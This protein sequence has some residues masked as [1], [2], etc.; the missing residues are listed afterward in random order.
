MRGTFD[1]RADAAYIYLVDEIAPGESTRQVPLEGEGLKAMVI[2]DFD[3]N[4]RLL[5]VEIIG[6][7][8]TLRQ[9]T[10]AAFE[11]LS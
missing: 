5:G 1:P 11:A 10:L 9:D 2:L 6:A 8:G 3:S 4:D 7:T